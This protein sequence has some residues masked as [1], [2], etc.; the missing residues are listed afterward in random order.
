MKVRSFSLPDTEVCFLPKERPSPE[1]TQSIP[2]SALAAP[3]KIPCTATGSRS[4]GN[5]P[6]KLP[7]IR[8]YP[9]DA[10]DR[11]EL[12][13]FKKQLHLKL[14][15]AQMGNAKNPAICTQQYTTAKQLDSISGP[16]L[17]K[18]CEFSDSQSAWSSL[19]AQHLQTT[20]G[21]QQQLQGNPAVCKTLCEGDFQTLLL[22]IF[23]EWW[24]CP[25]TQYIQPLLHVSVATTPFG[26][27]KGNCTELIIRNCTELQQ[28]RHRLLQWS[29]ALP[30]SL[31]VGGSGC[32]WGPWT[33]S[34]MSRNF[35][36]A[37][38]H[39]LFH[40]VV[41]KVSV[42]HMTDKRSEQMLILCTQSR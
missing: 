20:W 6:H 26:E 35:P 4:E 10:A 19:G 36:C 1:E 39:T 37:P 14:Q 32:L 5:K 42:T 12:Q 7:Q 22:K 34:R 38:L 21:C 29:Q 24:L 28:N 25:D 30:T 27:E 16:E 2:S 17:T 15:E 18:T 41:R 40:T 8:K 23:L 9:E 13:Q 31:S 33:H 11:L 3:A